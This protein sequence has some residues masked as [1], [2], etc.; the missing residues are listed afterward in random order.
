MISFEERSFD[1]KMNHFMDSPESG[2]G[3]SEGINEFELSTMLMKINRKF[4]QDIEQ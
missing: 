3:G 1:E 2:F 4:G